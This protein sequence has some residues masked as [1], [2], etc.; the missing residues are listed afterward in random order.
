MIATEFPPAS[1]ALPAATQS[2]AVTH[3]MLLNTLYVPEV[4]LGLGITS[5]LQLEPFHNWEAAANPVPEGVGPPDCS[6]TQS[7]DQ[8]AKQWVGEVQESAGVESITSLANGCGLVTTAHDDP[9]QASTISCVEG[10][11]VPIGGGWTVPAARQNVL[12]GHD[13][14]CKLTDP[15]TGGVGISFH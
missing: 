10:T 14:A 12:V 11:D 13:T 5:T 2:S 9:F 4:S 3:D 15:A 8:T 7:E 6:T 1:S